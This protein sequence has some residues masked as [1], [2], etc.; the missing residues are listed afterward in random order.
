MGCPVLLSMG[1]H[2]RA[3][4]VGGTWKSQHVNTA[5][6]QLRGERTMLAAYSQINELK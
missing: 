1:I 4:R 2:V 5:Y 6:I 3:F